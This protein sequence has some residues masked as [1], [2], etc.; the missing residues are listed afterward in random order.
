VR[1]L[2]L[3]IEGFTSFRERVELDFTGLDLFAVTGPTGA[4]KSSLVD[5]LV[6]ALYGQV[7]RVGKEYRQL[8]SHGAERLSVSLDF[9]MD[10]QEYRVVR[11]ARAV[12]NVQTRLERRQGSQWRPVADRVKDIGE[13]IE[14]IV[15][16][17]YDAF[18][19]SVVLPQ[20][21]FDAFLKGRSEERRRI[22][23]ALLNLGVY[24]DMMSVA[25]RRATEARARADSLARQLADDYAGA[26]PENAA[27]RRR[28]L[29]EAQ[30]ELGRSER[31]VAAL[32]AALQAALAVRQ[33]RRERD[34]AARDAAVEA[35][36][37]AEAERALAAVETE[38]AELTRRLD[39]AEPPGPGPAAADE[40]RYA[41]LL[42]TRPGVEQLVEALPRLERR[43]AERAARADQLDRCR[44]TFGESEALLAARE[45]QMAERQVAVEA[46]RT[47][48]DESRRRHAA[49]E[50]RQHL[51]PGAECPVCAQSVAVIPPPRG[52]ALDAARARLSEEEAAWEAARAGA[53][54][55]RLEVERCRSDERLGAARL[56][57]LQAALAEERR[58]VQAR[59]EA[60]AAGGVAPLEL[61]DPEDLLRRIRKDLAR[62]D[63]ARDAR[64]R[65]EAERRRLADEK[66]AG[67]LARAAA[68]A[69]AEGARARRQELAHRQQEA[70]AALA[71]ATQALAA[72]GVVE[73][74]GRVHSAPA[75]STRGRAA[76]DEVDHLESRRAALER[77]R[78][79]LAGRVE[80]LKAE[81]AHL[82]R[83]VARAADLA[84][85][86]KALEA[87]AAVAAMLALE[88]RG[89]RFQGYVQQEALGRLAADASEHLL[90]L[91]QG[92]YSLRGDEQEFVVVDHWNAEQVRSV[93][94]LS[95][96]ETFLASLALA[97]ALAESLAA[98][99]AEGRAGEALGSLFLD[100]GFGT[101][102][103][104]TLDLVV[105]AIEALHGGRRLVGVVTH[106][107]E[108]AE[109]LPARVEVRRGP[110]GA[111]LGVV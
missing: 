84:E 92:R 18:V 79:E 38:L 17:D 60:L 103:P 51:V 31:D 77:Q 58:A 9:G 96:G 72:L 12:G 24:S 85:Q 80:R 48:L 54:A 63:A 87:K 101:L 5:A 19:R 102:D 7:P 108:L 62:L 81:A 71:S 33:A 90:R 57:D 78:T 95:G 6:F 34:A 56:Q 83:A 67:E 75:E 86:K 21:Q 39:Q 43:E 42:A 88:L 26:T 47:A 28:E 94:T 1:P 22:L 61:A 89:D 3:T 69:R 64:A 23:V 10:G 107:A 105:Q 55:A 4:G 2:R 13:E 41:S 25:G 40:A 68:Q 65:R 36:R 111:V 30:R 8:V 15:G 110:G 46:A 50:L 49:H 66:A 11:T 82:E 74:P 99:S 53:E 106:I 35:A 29:E 37:Q 14:R 52:E 104:E 100:E 20:G 91:S 44:E 70:E 109:R 27:A 32:A 59:R 76:P 73:A 16:L 45:G 97:L 98:L 93:K